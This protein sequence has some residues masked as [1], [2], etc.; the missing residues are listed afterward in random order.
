MHT[1]T[2]L[3]E[4]PGMALS[5]FQASGDVRTAVESKFSSFAGVDAWR[6]FASKLG[7]FSR[8]ICESLSGKMLS[9]WRSWWRW[10]CHRHLLPPC[11]RHLAHPDTCFLCSMCSPKAKL[12]TSGPTT[13][14]FMTSAFAWK[15]RLP[16]KSLRSLLG[17]TKIY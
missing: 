17:P 13:Q 5:L 11:R 14:R 12:R 6:S 3:W 9:L 1:C 8:L 15:P 7:V 4:A 16:D 10:T 2:C